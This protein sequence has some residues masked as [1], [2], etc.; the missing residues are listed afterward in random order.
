MPASVIVHACVREYV[1]SSSLG[2]SHLVACL[3]FL[4]LAQDTLISLDVIEEQ[5][6]RAA[7]DQ[8]QFA[9]FMRAK[10]VKTKTLVDVDSLAT[11]CAKCV[12]VCHE[13]CYLEFIAEKGHK[14]FLRCSCIS[15]DG[16]CTACPGTCSHEVRLR[17]CWFDCESA[18]LTF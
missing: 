16:N 12:H 18:L 2:S 14:D 1:G 8:S 10:T 11:L 17:V 5:M 15:G 9:A 7:A 13:G 6:E 4:P 3:S